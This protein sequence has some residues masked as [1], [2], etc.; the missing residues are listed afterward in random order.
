MSPNRS[1]SYKLWRAMASSS[2]SYIALKAASN[3]VPRTF[4]AGNA[5]GSGLATWA[6]G[7]PSSRTPINAYNPQGLGF[8]TVSPHSLSD[9][10][11]GMFP[12]R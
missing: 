5:V 3:P 12:Q 8:R 4:L 10:A 11:G 7:L 9:A 2:G 6:S 1:W